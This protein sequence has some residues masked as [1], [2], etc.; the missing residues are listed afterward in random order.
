MVTTTNTIT[1][2]IIIISFINNICKFVG[3]KDDYTFIATQYKT[4]VH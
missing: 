1:I 4:A 3:Q 2:T